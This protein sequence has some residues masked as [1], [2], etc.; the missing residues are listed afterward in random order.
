MTEIRKRVDESWKEQVEKEKQV[1]D[2]LKAR[3]GAP[4]SI[5]P[6][7][8]PLEAPE[9]EAESPIIGAGPEAAEPGGEEA[10]GLPEARF[11]L[12]LSGLA[13]DALI[14]LGDMPHPVTKK[15]A[16]NLDHARYL[17]DLLGILAEKTKNNLT[18]DEDRLLK[19]TLYQLRMRYLNKAGPRAG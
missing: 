17:I 15:P 18:A 11:D 5:D 6:A 2:E 7:V 14:G 8:A 1:A 4:A 3:K 12:F 13:V 19:D 10:G 9:A 16:V